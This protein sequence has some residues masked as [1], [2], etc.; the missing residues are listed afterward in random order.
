MKSTD[1]EKILLRY[2]L[3]KS[4]DGAI[5]DDEIKDFH[6]LIADYP[7]LEEYYVKCI[8]LYYVLRESS[9]GKEIGFVNSMA[10]DD[11]IW[12]DMAKLENSAPKIEILK[13]KLEP[14]PEPAPT[15][16]PARNNKLSKFELIAFAISTAAVLFIAFLVIFSPKK[17][18]GLE[19]ATLTDQIN[20]QWGDTNTSLR[21]GERLFISDE[22]ISLKTGIV[23]IHYDNDVEVVVEGPAL[24]EIE[25]SG[26]YL[27]YGRLFSSVSDSGTGFSVETPSC[28]FVDLGTEFGVQADINNSAELHVIKGKVQLFAG[29]SN[30]KKASE[31]VHENNAVRFDSYAETTRSIPVQTNT[32]VRNANSKSKVIWRGQDSLN[33][34]DIVG[35]GNGFGKGVLG[36][37]IDCTDGS[38]TKQF[39][40]AD[41]NVRGGRYVSVDSIPFIDGV[42]VPDLDNDGVQATSAGDIFAE[43][44]DTNGKFWV[45]IKDGGPHSTQQGIPEHMLTLA[46]IEYGTKENPS[47][48][49]HANQ[50]ITFDLEEIRNNFPG[51]AVDRFTATCGLSDSIFTVSP[52]YSRG[53]SDNLP[54]GDFWVLVDGQ[55][56]FSKIGQTPIDDP[57]FIDILLDNNDRFLTLVTTDNDQDV[58]YVWS[59]FAKP[60]L[61]IEYEK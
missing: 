13:P 8:H 15:V 1:K 48:F 19:V 7:D 32:F 47:I 21:N 58:A 42:F 30:Q 50:G 53:N 5:T 45:G 36:S 27:T 4:L 34:A 46:G 49:I 31:I 37:G 33:L 11:Q 16:R 23:K 35:G 6:K 51:S 3:N 10:L 14:E 28:K 18:Y 26:V 41:Y 2:L 22:P 55:V 43:C 44:P 38:Y 25:R 56:R 40:T 9:I 24:F 52:E 60:M 39:F 61:H 12:T 17:N 57:Q 59:L 20:V 54:V 29:N